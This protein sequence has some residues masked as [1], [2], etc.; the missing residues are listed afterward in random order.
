MVHFYSGSGTNG[1]RIQG[2]R[3]GSLSPDEDPPVRQGIALTDLPLLGAHFEFAVEEI[4]ELEMKHLGAMKGDGATGIGLGI[5]K[6]PPREWIQSGP[7]SVTP[8][9]AT[10]A[11]LIQL[12]AGET[13]DLL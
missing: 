11:I 6:D 1:V 4:D 7:H 9:P 3:T 8:S 5:T 10:H 2:G 12:K 13:A